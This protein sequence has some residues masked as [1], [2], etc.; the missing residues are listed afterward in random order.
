MLRDRRRTNRIAVTGM[1]VVSPL[2]QSTAE[3]HEAL[4]AGRSGI[5]RWRDV[6]ERVLARVGGDMSDF[7]LDAHLARHGTSYN[8][9]LAT[10]LRRT[11]RATPLP[12]K[13]TA[14][15][16]LQAFTDAGLPNAGADPSRMG[17]V[18]GGH[19]L[20][21]R[22]QYDNF[23]LFRDEPDFI[24]PLFGLMALDTD[25]LSVTSEVLGIKG[26]TMTVGAAC[27]SGNM[28][29]LAGLDLIRADRADVVLVTGAA[30]DLDSVWLQGWTIME[31]LAFRSFNDDP[32]RASRPF[33]KHREGFVPSEGA[34]AIILESEAH[35]RKRGARVRAEL[36]GAFATSAASR[37]TRPDLETQVL[38]MRGAL[39]DAGVSASRVDYVNAHA[40]STPLGDAIEV[41][42]IKAALEQ[43]AYSIPVNST[44]SMLGHCLTSASVLEMIATIL[45]IDS[46]MVHPTI[47][48]E[49]PDPELDLDFVPGRARPHAI[50]LAMSNAFGFGGLNSSVVVGRWLGP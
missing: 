46:Q 30:M 21:L 23:E 22:Y 4:M 3:Y 34:G 49:T 29:L 19:N 44:K 36:L 38:A 11:L 32:E 50:D 40:T 12:G 8:A 39:S 6:D 13:L 35:A 26:V 25:V 24:D 33:D 45:Q 41:S 15:A 43:R 9:D 42:A 16:A 5:R 28:A 2:G 18:L 20:Q 27:A 7:D 47:N 14:A 37:S 1:G 17:H 10:R 31:A 48:L